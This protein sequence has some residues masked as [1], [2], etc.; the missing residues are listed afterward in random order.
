MIENIKHTVERIHHEKEP[1]NT[2]E[3]EIVEEEEAKAEQEIKDN[4]KSYLSRTDQ[5]SLRMNKVMHQ[6]GHQ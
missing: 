3:R 1:N 6:A 5:F 4:I 2:F